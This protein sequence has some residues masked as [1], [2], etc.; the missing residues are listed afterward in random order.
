[1]WSRCGCEEPLLTLLLDH[2][3]CSSSDLQHYIKLT[4]H[5]TSP[6]ITS[7]HLTLYIIPYAT[8]H[9]IIGNTTLYHMLHYIT[10]CYITCYTIY[11]S[12]HI[13]SHYITLHHITSHYIILHHITSWS[14]L[15][16]ALPQSSPWRCADSVPT[17]WAPSNWTP[18][19]HHQETT[20]NNWPARQM[21]TSDTSTN[22]DTF[23]LVYKS[24]F[25]PQ[26]VSVLKLQTLGD[27]MYIA[28]VLQLSHWSNVKKRVIIKGANH[29]P[30][31][32][33]SAR[34]CWLSFPPPSPLY[35][36]PTPVHLP[37]V[38]HGV[39]GERELLADGPGHPGGRW[40]CPWHGI[41]QASQ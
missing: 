27:Y 15:Y 11:M 29:P 23:N 38:T 32:T 28:T 14:Q 3:G 24:T 10:P 21:N 18:A 31:H 17:H 34:R 36:L 4:A 19:E 8:A 40:S 35:E 22:Q 12:H 16:P 1:M 2:F 9:Y 30:S 39:W 5:V 7:Y 33:T 20:M 26:T 37:P 6:N 25:L 13:T 41:Q